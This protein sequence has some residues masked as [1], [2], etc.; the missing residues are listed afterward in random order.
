MQTYACKE[1]GGPWG[2]QD[3][4][5]NCAW[6]KKNS[7]RIALDTEESCI[8]ALDTYKVRLYHIPYKMRSIK[9]CMRAVEIKCGYIE[10]VPMKLRTNTLCKHALQSA[11]DEGALD[12]SLM[13]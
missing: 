6:C 4:A 12:V 3:R 5:S 1:C 13:I 2:T 9:V 10:H 8:K 7:D 11:Y